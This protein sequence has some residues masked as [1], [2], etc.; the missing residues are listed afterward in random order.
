M[1]G[2]APRATITPVRLQGTVVA[3]HVGAQKTG[4]LRAVPHVKAVAGR[5]L[6]GDRYFDRDGTFSG[7][8][9]TGREVTLVEEEV[10]ASVRESGIPLEAAETR[11]NLLTRGVRLDD[12]VGRRFRVGD[13]VLEGR[14]RC[15]PCA[16]LES[17][18][19]PGVL[20]ALVGRGGLRADVVGGGTIRAG[21]PIE[22][23]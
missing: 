21:D 8:P 7:R 17:L 10:V 13:A 5:G 22:E 11:R 12:L 9:G 1:S 15:E 18:T 14:R 20:A 6:E 23:T 2:A 19:R 3:V 4:P 16:H